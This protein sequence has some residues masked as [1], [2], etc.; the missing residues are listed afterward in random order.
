MKKRKSGISGVQKSN[1]APVSFQEWRKKFESSL[2]VDT[3]AWKAFRELLKREKQSSEKFHLPKPED[4]RG[5]LLRRIYEETS[6]RPQDENAPALAKTLKKLVPQLSAAIAVIS[7]SGSKVVTDGGLGLDLSSDLH[8]LHK[9]RNSAT[10][11][12]GLLEAK[13][14]ESLRRDASDQGL[15]FLS[16]L[17]GIGTEMQANELCKLALE[18][19]GYPDVELTDL[20][21][22]NTRGG[23]IRHRKDTLRKLNERVSLKIKNYALR[24]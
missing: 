8:L 24:S 4:V 20:D 5:D 11:T 22:S 14:P 23:K 21:I 1:P 3:P 17:D 15:W 2:R 6:P 12:L 16:M 10:A 13:G 7:I 19:H 18:A 9:V